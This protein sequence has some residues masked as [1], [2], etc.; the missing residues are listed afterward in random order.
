MPDG[1]TRR[2]AVSLIKDFAHFAETFCG[3]AAPSNRAH[4]RRA[5]F[6]AGSDLEIDQLVE[7]H[8]GGD[9]SSIQ[10]VARLHCPVT[11]P[12]R[13]MVNVKVAES[14]PKRIVSAAKLVRKKFE[15][16]ETQTCR[17][18]PKRQ[19]CRFFKAPAAEEEVA[20]VPHLNRVIFGMAQYSRA[21]LEHPTVY[22]FYFGVPELEAARTL[23]AGIGDQLRESSLPL[24]SRIEVASEEESKAILE[25]LKERKLQLKQ[26]AAEERVL[27]LPAWMRDRLQPLA[28]PGM[29]RKQRRLLEEGEALRSTADDPEPIEKK[30]PQ[31]DETAWVEEGSTPGEPTGA[32]LTEQFDTSGSRPAVPS[33]TA[34]TKTTTLDAV[35]KLSSPL[36]FEH[37]SPSQRSD[38][39]LHNSPLSSATQNIHTT[40]V[41]LD[42][43]TDMEMDYVPMLEGGYTI[44]DVLQNA[45]TRQDDG[46]D[47]QKSLESF[48]QV[49]PHAMQ[50]VHSYSVEAKPKSLDPSV[51]ED[52]WKRAAAGQGELPFL[53]RVPFDVGVRRSGGA[54]PPGRID[55]ELLQT[56]PSPEI[57]AP[58]FRQA[59]SEDPLVDDSSRASEQR[60]ETFKSDED[61]ISKVLNTEVRR[62]PKQQS[63]SDSQKSSWKPAAMSVLEPRID[64]GSLQNPGRLDNVGDMQSEIDVAI[65]RRATPQKSET[66][67]DGLPA[68]RRPLVGG[69][70]TDDPLGSAAPGVDIASVRRRLA[71]ETSPVIGTQVFAR[72]VEG[73]S[74]MAAGAFRFPRLPASEPKRMFDQP[75]PST[76]KQPPRLGRLRQAK[77]ADLGDLI[78]PS[79]KP[80]K[81]IGNLQS[82]FDVAAAA[83]EG[84]EAKESAL[85]A[86][87]L[88]NKRVALKVQQRFPSRPRDR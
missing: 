42:E 4:L 60:D 70:E 84:T 2:A 37:L 83:P 78:K 58:D 16:P 48:I 12:N 52:L 8:L 74:G 44:A 75:R 68:F 26:Q 43:V 62:M 46:R 14:A 33:V 32:I 77:V 67:D 18:C 13:T 19:R 53:S 10:T 47:A 87:R 21:H 29:T 30:K 25:R 36:R 3:C 15:M 54:L 79:S 81:A 56:S 72:N 71:D 31:R 7:R 64:I 45:R 41:D 9:A 17:G 86:Q 51:L 24:H 38:N 85:A 76:P 27:N 40:T 1:G 66:Q 22:P 73:E 82:P 80:P 6:Q 11:L 23:M 63:R 57:P 55:R 28:G 65:G 50:G 69:A 5:V 20:G 49:S 35:E 61:L 39:H 59:N 34:A 88:L